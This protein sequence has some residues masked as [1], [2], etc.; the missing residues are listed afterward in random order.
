M[1]PMQIINNFISKIANIDSIS[2][3]DMLDKKY[4]DSNNINVDNVSLF[5]GSSLLETTIIF[6]FVFKLFIYFLKIFASGSYAVFLISIISNLVGS[7]LLAVPIE[8]INLMLF[9]NE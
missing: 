2:V 5:N 9:F 6:C 1:N 7:I 4:I 3:Y 8:E